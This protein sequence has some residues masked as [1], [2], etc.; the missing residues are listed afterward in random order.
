MR[1]Y[2][3]HRTSLETPRATPPSH[4]R[5]YRY[6]VRLYMRHRT[7]LETQRRAD[8]FSFMCAPQTP[9][10]PIR[11]CNQSAPREPCC[12]NVRD[13]FGS[14]K[15]YGTSDHSNDAHRYSQDT[16]S[17]HYSAVIAP[18]GPAQCVMW[19]CAQILG[20]VVSTQGVC[21]CCC[22]VRKP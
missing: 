2:T 15:H 8:P 7:S 12:T 5:L 11:T 17:S 20:I 9:T 22:T 10:P 14:V 21:K 18:G 3:R 13:R 1:L 19:G 6:H 16:G 4:T